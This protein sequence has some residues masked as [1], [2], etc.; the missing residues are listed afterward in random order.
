[1]CSILQHTSSDV[2]KLIW[3]RLLYVNFCRNQEHIQQTQSFT[4]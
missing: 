3:A 4:L 1:M 2:S